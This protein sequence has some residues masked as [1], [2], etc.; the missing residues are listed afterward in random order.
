VNTIGCGLPSFPGSASSVALD[1][2]PGASVSMLVVWKGAKKS[3]L[4]PSQLMLVGLPSS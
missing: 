4:P 1:S 3:L 2:V